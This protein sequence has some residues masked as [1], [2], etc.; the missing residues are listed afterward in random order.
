MAL[1]EST[2]L[3]YGPLSNA[4][5]AVDEGKL[6]ARDLIIASDTHEFMYVDDDDQIQ[7]IVVRTLTFNNYET[8]LTSIN[9][10]SEVYLGQDVRILDSA[11]NRYVPY[12]IQADTNGGYTLERVTTENDGCTLK[13]EEF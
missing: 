8:A 1:A 10:M 6:D 12:I 11:T 7:K 13:W 3:G 4:Q 2:K 9:S 5:S